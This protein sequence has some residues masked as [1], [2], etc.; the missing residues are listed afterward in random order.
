MTNY[1]L[2]AISSAIGLLLVG[3]YYIS[4]IIHF[5]VV[6]SVLFIFSIV[7]V[8]TELNKSNKPQIKEKKPDVWQKRKKN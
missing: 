5:L 2:S 3:L 7:C 8:Y 6:S 1:R 4:D